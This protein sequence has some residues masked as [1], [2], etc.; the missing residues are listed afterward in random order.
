MLGIADY[1][2]RTWGKVQAARYLGELEDFCVALAD[3]P[4]LGRSCEEIRVG[5][6]RME[7]GSHVI[8]Y[9]AKGGGVLIS[10]ILHLR[11]LPEKHPID[12]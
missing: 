1:T 11:M 3:N 7:H 5:L 10:R 6:R 4:G 8:F 2:V 9:R 12:D